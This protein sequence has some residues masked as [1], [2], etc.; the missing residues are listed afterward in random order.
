MRVLKVP[1]EIAP[2][3]N[4]LAAPDAIL[5]AFVPSAPFHAP[6]ALNVETISLAGPAA[7]NFARIASAVGIPSADRTVLLSRSHA[8]TLA[9]F[10]GFVQQHPGAGILIFDAHPDALSAEQMQQIGFTLPWEDLLRG[11]IARKLVSPERILLIGMRVATGEEL[12]FLKQH[13]VKAFT[14][15]D[16]LNL[17]LTEFADTL[18]EV[19][20]SWPAVYCSIDF[21]VLDPAFAPAVDIPEPGGLSSAELLYVLRRLALLKNLQCVDICELAVEKDD[22]QKTAL[23]AAELMRVFG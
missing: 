23:V 12:A 19:V 17:G 22:E 13:H 18:T 1:L 15:M 9:A 7:E 8:V 2:S 5:A 4:P 21:D 3:V 11:L 20:R 16:I 6:L 14:M 10:S